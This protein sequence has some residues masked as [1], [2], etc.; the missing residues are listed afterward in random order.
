[1]KAASRKRAPTTVKRTVRRGRRPNGHYRTREYLTE[2]EVE[3]LMKAAGR[4]RYGHRD[5]SM[6]LLAFRHGLRASE[7][8]SLRWEQV[9]LT[10]A[11]L[12]VS[13]LNA[14]ATALPRAQEH[15]AHGSLHRAFARS[16]PGL[17]EGL[18]GVSRGRTAHLSSSTRV[19]GLWPRPMPLPHC[20]I[21]CPLLARGCAPCRAEIVDGLRGAVGEI[22]VLAF[23]EVSEFRDH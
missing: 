1:M 20:L 22:V 6:I 10:H 17:L 11:R 14:G 2:R 19:E 12:H 9:D 3:R 13:R 15:P 18:I 16:L 5:A 21:H 4:N 8:C 7:L 23:R